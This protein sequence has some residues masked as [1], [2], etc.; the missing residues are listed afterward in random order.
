MV[1]LVRTSVST[2][3]ASLKEKQ[4]EIAASLLR[5]AKKT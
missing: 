1:T 3:T 4:E 2:R 5:K